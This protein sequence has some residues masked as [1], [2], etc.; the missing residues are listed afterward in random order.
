MGKYF[1]KFTLRL[2]PRD[3]KIITKKARA[4]RMTMA[5]YLRWKVSK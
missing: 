2:T 3:K 5:E 4:K 1:I